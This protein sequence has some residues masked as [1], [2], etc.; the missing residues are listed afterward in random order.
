VPEEGLYTFSSRGGIEARLN[1]GVLFG[2]SRPAGALTV[3]LGA[4]RH[5]LVVVATAPGAVLRVTGPDGFVL[6]PA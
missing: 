5:E 3:R 2:R 4:G 6:P 1:G